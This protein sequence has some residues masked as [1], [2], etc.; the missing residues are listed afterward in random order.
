[1]TKYADGKMLGFTSGGRVVTIDET[2]ARSSGAAS[3][4][5]S[6]WGAT[7]NPVLW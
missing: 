2:S 6:W 4:A 3:L 7:T 5:G 1:M